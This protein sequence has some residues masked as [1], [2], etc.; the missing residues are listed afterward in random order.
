MR[1]F[2]RGFV[3]ILILGLLAGAIY[4]RVGKQRDQE[5]LPRVGQAVDIGGRS[6]NI[7]CS[8]SGSPSV[9]LD[10]GGSAP[11]YSNMPLQRLIAKET[12]AC[13]FDRAGLGWSDPSPVTQTSAAI[14]ADLHELLRAVKMD[15]PYILVGQSFSGF[16]VRVF[17]KAH[18]S[19]VAGVVLLDSVQE[20]Q[21]QYEPR[22]TLAPVNRLPAVV[23]GG[24]CRATPLAAKIG[25][26]RLVMSASGPDRRVPS[27]FT[28]SEA[29]VLHRLESQPKAIVASSGCD[30]WEKS[31]AEAREAGSLGDVRLVVLTAGKPMTVGN[32]E[33]DRDIQAF[34]EI[35]VPQLQPRLAAL[36]TRGRQVIVKE[37][38][39]A[40]A[41]DMPS[42]AVEAVRQILSDSRGR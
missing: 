2:V 3:V 33:D 32:P 30:V 29:I 42:A 31:A 6:L 14:A 9:I 27:G 19:E 5:Q 26:I 39:H 4:E 1:V 15:P 13:W 37:S 21:Q 24:L 7:Y 34:P 25:L 11:G 23:R 41:G 12:R 22:S 40:I 18:P 35:W 28:P 8:G 10:T 20:D 16:N 17:T 38:S 36:S